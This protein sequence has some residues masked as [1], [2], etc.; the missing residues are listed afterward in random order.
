MVQLRLWG[1][2]S[3]LSGVLKLGEDITDCGIWLGGAITSGVLRLFGYEELA[4]QIE[5]QTMDEIAYDGV[6][7]FNKLIYGETELGKRL[8]D[9]SYMKYDSNVAQVIQKVSE[10]A[11]LIAAAT[12]ATA[13]TGGV[14]APLFAAGFAVG[15][16]GSA[17]RKFQD[18]EN[19]SFW[20]DSAWITLDGTAKGFE[21]VA[22]G[23]IVKQ[24]TSILKSG[25]EAVKNILNANLR[26]V[27]R[28]VFRDGLWGITKNAAKNTVKELET[29]KDIGMVISDDFVRGFQTGEWDFKTMALETASSVATNFGSNLFGEVSS[30]ILN[31]ALVDGKKADWQSNSGI[32]DEIVKTAEVN[33]DTNKG[34]FTSEVDYYRDLDYVENKTTHSRKKNS[35]GMLESKNK[36]LSESDPG[37][38]RCLTE[39]RKIEWNNEVA[40]HTVDGKVRVNMGTTSAEIFDRYVVDDELLGRE[41]DY[42]FGRLGGTFIDE[43]Y[44]NGTSIVNTF[45][46]D[47]GIPKSRNKRV[48][49]YSYEVDEKFVSKHTG[50]E[51]GSNSQRLP[52]C[53]L[54]DGSTEVVI[55]STT[56]KEVGASKALDVTILDDNGS[57][58]FRGSLEELQNIKQMDIER[59]KDILNL[60]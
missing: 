45:E 37:I 31:K 34:D 14:S 21:T 19:R 38:T 56:V 33:F 36:R 54:P 20:K 5:Q 44:A 6:G 7:E 60:P 39:E 53:R 10:E 22:Q 51:L 47:T 24:A 43:K 42:N 27:G 12:A 59:Y 46:S 52:G 48:I 29:Y 8:N 9:N 26:Q 3:V 58:K 18:V 17:E 25:G 32:T 16:G 4:I 40:S 57:L 28:D 11:I 2:T 13:A 35:Q 49:Q 41:G 1:V 30:D 15:A 23:K 50:K 55:N